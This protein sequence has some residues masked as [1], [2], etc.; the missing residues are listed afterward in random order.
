[1]NDIYDIDVVASSANIEPHANKA[2]DIRLRMNPSQICDMLNE[3]PLNEIIKYLGQVNDI[4]KIL[5]THLIEPE[6]VFEHIGPSEIKHRVA[7]WLID[8][9]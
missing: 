8:N 1:M 5:C 9:A 3:I 6:D 2:I 7:Q 4:T